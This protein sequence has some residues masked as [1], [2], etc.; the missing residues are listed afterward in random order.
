M[1]LLGVACLRGEAVP[2]STKS[3][4][5]K[6]NMV[7]I[8]FALFVDAVSLFNKGMRGGRMQIIFISS[9]SWKKPRRV[10]HQKA[11][12]WWLIPC[13]AFWQLFSYLNAAIDLPWTRGRRPV[14]RSFPSLSVLFR[15][16]LNSICCCLKGKDKE[17]LIIQ[18]ITSQP[19]ITEGRKA[20][21]SCVLFL[22]DKNFY[23]PLS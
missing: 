2:R 10:S 18:M 16:W 5:H 13:G 1:C 7:Q 3:G 20:L 6:Q 8:Q 21:G 12:C 14:S 19:V 9:P 4:L 23:F 15:K 11:R 22:K 17:S